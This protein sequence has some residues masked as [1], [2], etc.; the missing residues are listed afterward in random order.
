MF[1]RKACLLS[2]LEHLA[3]ATVS[4]NCSENIGLGKLVTGVRR[5]VLLSSV[6]TMRDSI[7]ARASSDARNLLR[8][9]VFIGCVSRGSIIVQ[10]STN[11]LLMR[12]H[13]LMKELFYQLMVANFANHGEVYFFLIFV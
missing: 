9:C 10:Q 8:E 5:P 1:F 3:P 6:M 11:L 13:P 2:Q 4:H 12:L 7:E